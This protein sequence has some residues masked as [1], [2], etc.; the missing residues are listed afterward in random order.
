MM[1]AIAIMYHDIVARD[2]PDASGFPGADAALY[3]IES[4]EFEKHLESIARA[5]VSSPLSVFELLSRDARETENS[6]PWLLT[7]DDGG[8]SAVSIADA[9]EQKGWRGHFFVTAD[10]VNHPTFLS[11]AQIQDLHR[12]GH[13]IGSH[14]YSHP[15]RMSALSREE[16]LREWR[17]STGALAEILGEQV[18]VASVPGGYYSAAVA[19]TAAEC[20]IKAL[21]TSEPTMKSHF[22]NDCLVLGRYT[23]QRWMSAET[24]AQIAMGK[25]GPRLRQAALWQAKKITKAVGGEQYLKVRKMLFGEGTGRS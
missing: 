16:M 13:V 11:R 5:Q 6:R 8:A 10:C 19:E 9:L 2:A 17:E 4:A 1:K 3:K 18:A 25:V 23:I 20:G 14:S 7:F 15:V 22:V 24:A 12:R 21:F